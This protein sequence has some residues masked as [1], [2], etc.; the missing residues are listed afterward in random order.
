MKITYRTLAKLIERM[1]EYQKDAD[2]TI[3]LSEYSECYP[4]SLRICGE[5][6]DS[7]N[8]SH[9][10]IYVDI[11]DG[12]RINNIDWICETIGL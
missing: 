4:A 11:E 2:V 5:N 3:E 6:H 8:D 10:V 7:L 1:S 12:D 9:P